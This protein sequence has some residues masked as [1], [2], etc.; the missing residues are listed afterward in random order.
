[1]R[2]ENRAA[3]SDPVQHSAVAS[4]A[5]MRD[6]WIAELLLIALV[7]CVGVLFVWRHHLAFDTGT[8]YGTRSSAR[9]FQLA[10]PGR[11]LAYGSM[12]FFVCLRVRWYRRVW[13]SSPS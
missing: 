9:G 10:L 12:P 2:I 3:P 11:W 13:G 1:M 8:W 7:Y 4:A 5:R 6:S